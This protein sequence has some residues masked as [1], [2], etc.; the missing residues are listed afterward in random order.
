MIG[1]L[2][3]D[4]K[5]SYEATGRTRQKARTREALITAARELVAS[6]ADPTVESVAEAAG[7]SRTTAYRYFAS[8]DDLLRAAH[9][10]V[11]LTS[12][13]P[14]D[15]PEDVE[16]RLG[17]VLDQHFRI[18]REWEPQLRA[19]LAVSLRPGTSAPPLRGGRAIGWIAD[20]LAPLSSDQLSSEGDVRDLAVRIR[21]VAG[22]EPFVWLVDVAGLSRRSAFAVMRENAY[23]V[24]AAATSR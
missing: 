16:A 22:I 20:A 7:I 12:L 9:P 3:H 19:S 6:G 2:C 23:A 8:A 4:G 15:A 17:L 24:L 13:L 5:V 10:E 1:R 14:T 18:I 11:E 21:S